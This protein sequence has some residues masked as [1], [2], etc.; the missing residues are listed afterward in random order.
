VV[1]YTRQIYD[2]WPT[3]R[4]TTALTAKLEEV[5]TTSTFVAVLKS[6]EPAAVC[7]SHLGKAIFGFTQQGIIGYHVGFGLVVA[8]G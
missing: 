6:T 2:D 8:Q 4:Q 1:I 7:M 5:G 3:A